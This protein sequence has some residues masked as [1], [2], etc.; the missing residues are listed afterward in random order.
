MSKKKSKRSKKGTLPAGLR[1]WMAEQRKKKQNP[2]RRKKARKNPPRPRVRVVTRTRVR[3]K[4]V[5]RNPPRK[6]RTR[7]PSKRTRKP[8]EVRLRGS[9]TPGQLKNI[10]SLISRATGKKVVLK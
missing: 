9:Y 7:R 3:I 2:R 4:T 5:Y 10:K 8:S 1:K 6:K